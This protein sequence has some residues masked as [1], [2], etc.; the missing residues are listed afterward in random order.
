LRHD[1]I[2]LSVELALEHD[3]FIDDGDDAIERLGAG[4]LS[5]GNVRRRERRGSEYEGE[6]E[7]FHGDFRIRL[8]STAMRAGGLIVSQ[9]RRAPCAMRRLSGATAAM[10]PPGTTP[11]Y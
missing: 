11:S 7:I 4:R 5:A 6:Y 10:G 1:L 3:I 8:I 9:S 2:D